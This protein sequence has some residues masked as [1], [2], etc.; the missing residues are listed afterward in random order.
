MRG[1]TLRGEIRPTHTHTHRMTSAW[2]QTDQGGVGPR[3]PQSFERELNEF[4]Q[5][6]TRY[7]REKNNESQQLDWDKIRSPTDD[8]VR[9]PRGRGPRHPCTDMHRGAA[10][11]LGYLVCVW[12]CGWGRVKAHLC[13]ARIDSAVPCIGAGGQVGGQGEPGQARRPE[14]ER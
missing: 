6:F 12:V 2:A 4:Y 1:E 11:M 8:Q 10:C 9:A 14:A 3:L 5:L 7:L 13:G